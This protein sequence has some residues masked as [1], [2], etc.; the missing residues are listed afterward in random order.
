MDREWLICLR[1]TQRQQLRH[2]K[3]LIGVGEIHRWS[4]LH[5]LQAGPSLS[6]PPSTL[7]PTP[8]SSCLTYLRELPWPPLGKLAAPSLLPE[9]NASSWK[10]QLRCTE[11]GEFTLQRVLLDDQTGLTYR[12][13]EAETKSSHRNWEAKGWRK[14]QCLE[15]MIQTVHQFPWREKPGLSVPVRSRRAGRAQGDD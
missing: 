13:W 3:K 5:N 8:A 9:R 7:T 12:I 15:F 6:S 4:S 2:Q 1:V 10:K 11:P 14:N